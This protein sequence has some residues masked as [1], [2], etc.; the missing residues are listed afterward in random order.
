MEKPFPYLYPDPTKPIIPPLHHR[1]G[2]GWLIFIGVNI[3]I[4]IAAVA[5]FLWF[6]K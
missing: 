1:I 4:P 6:N 5:A 3:F 2:I